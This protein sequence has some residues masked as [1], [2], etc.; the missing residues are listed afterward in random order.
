V[1]ATRC[2]TGGEAACALRRLKEALWAWARDRVTG[3]EATSARDARRDCAAARPG[4]GGGAPW[5]R[6]RAPRLGAMTAAARGR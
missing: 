1:Q 4:A 6:V 2:R 5:K 3:L